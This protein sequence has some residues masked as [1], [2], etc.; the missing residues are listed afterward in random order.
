MHVGFSMAQKNGASGWSSLA[1][2][3]D[4]LPGG[5]YRDEYRLEPYF[6]HLVYFR[7]NQGE[8][9][10]EEVVWFSKLCQAI[11]KLAQAGSLTNIR[12]DEPRELTREDL[13]VA[14]AGVPVAVGVGCRCGNSN[15]WHTWYAWVIDGGWHLECHPF[16]THFVCP[17]CEGHIDKVS[18]FKG[19]G[20]LLGLRALVLRG[21]PVDLT[22][23]NSGS[24]SLTAKGNPL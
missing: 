21:E 16:S 14:L 10:S 3:G 13:R 24:I 17:A 18:P 2:P 4:E 11:D 12:A 5:A 6:S 20:N 7:I 19:W 9:A 1:R 8:M 15:H 22:L 23:L